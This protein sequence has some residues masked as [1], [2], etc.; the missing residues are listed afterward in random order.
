MPQLRNSAGALGIGSSKPGPRCPKA[1]PA[2]VRLGMVKRNAQ[3]QG[4]FGQ[5]SGIRS[6]HCTAL[7]DSGLRPSGS[8]E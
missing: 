5:V 6:L 4:H 8:G 7:Q 3:D 2:Q 1:D